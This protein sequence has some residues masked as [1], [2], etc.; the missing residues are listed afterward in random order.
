MSIHF[1]LIRYFDLRMA[2]KPND[3]N[4]YTVHA[5]FGDPVMKELVNIKSFLISHAKEII[6]LD[7]QHFYGF[8]EADH[9]RLSSVLKSLFH[10]MICPYSYPIENLT[11]DTM[12]KNSW[13]VMILCMN[14]NIH[15][16]IIQDSCI[17]FIYYDI[18]F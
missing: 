3:A 12:R 10:N 13:Q 18:M 14:I 8:S 6:V 15:L 4:F 11:L 9:S 1:L 2:V 17:F 7:F 16:I 5:L